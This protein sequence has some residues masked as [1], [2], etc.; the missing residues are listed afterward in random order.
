MENFQDCGSGPSWRLCIAERGL[1][2]LS[3]GL[4][5]WLRKA[6]RDGALRMK[7]SWLVPKGVGERAAICGAR[8]VTFDDVWNTWEDEPWV[9][10]SFLTIL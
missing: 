3:A 2:R 9:M 4:E 7:P 8:V 5:D 10:L 6:A 1:L